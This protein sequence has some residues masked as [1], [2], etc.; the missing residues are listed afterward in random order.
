MASAARGLGLWDSVQA[1]EEDSWILHPV[2]L[3]ASPG[4]LQITLVVGVIATFSSFC[5]ILARIPGSQ[6]QAL[7][8]HFCGCLN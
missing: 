1:R 5:G 3:D 8:G 6:I 7:G 2:T 4:S